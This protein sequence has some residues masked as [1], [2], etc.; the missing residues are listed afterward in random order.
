M[1]SKKKT[2]LD[3][4][5]LEAAAEEVGQIAAREHVRVALIGGLAMQHYGSP[6]LTGDVDVVVTRPIEGLTSIGLLT[7][8]GY[9]A[10]TST[11][12][13]VDVV[14]RDD[15]YAELYSEALNTAVTMEAGPMRI[16][17]PEYL[18]VMKMEAGRKR[19]DAD[20]EF[21]ITEAVIDVPKTR[22]VVLRHLGRYAAREFTALV[23]ETLWRLS[24]R[25]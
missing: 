19:D 11:D 25:T 6:R 13:P 8:G 7:F 22:E 10:V 24:R 4:H 9:K 2:F 5:V 12:V 3:P 23:D 17:R 15:D 1:S 14:L 20:L 21:L 18:A 16:V